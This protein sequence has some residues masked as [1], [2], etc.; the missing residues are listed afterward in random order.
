[1]A[2]FSRTPTNIRTSFS[3]RC[4]ADGL[5]SSKAE[6][7]PRPHG[8]YLRTASLRVDESATALLRARA[9]IKSERLNSCTFAL[10]F[11]FGDERYYER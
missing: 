9:K 5:V 4:C 3:N 10:P 11:A 6:R 7:L 2:D 8:H 1:M